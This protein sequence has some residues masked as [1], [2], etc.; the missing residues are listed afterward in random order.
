[1]GLHRGFAEVEL[2]GDVQV[3]QAT[4]D[5]DDVLPHHERDR[6]DAIYPYVSRARGDKIVLDV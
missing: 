1:M 5:R 4:G 3:G 2:G 6:T